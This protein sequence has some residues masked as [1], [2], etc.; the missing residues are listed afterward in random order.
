[1]KKHRLDSRLLCADLVGVC[2]TDKTGLPH[3]EI[4]NLEAISVYGASLV[5]DVGVA[6][7]TIV[8]LCTPRGSF[9]AAIRECHHEPDF[10]FAMHVELADRSRW[11]QRGYRPRHL[12]DPSGLERR[13]AQRNRTQ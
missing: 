6:P 8:K 10:G 9:D 1:M 12:F 5:L 2:W 7:G 13:E 11:S 3:S 4:A